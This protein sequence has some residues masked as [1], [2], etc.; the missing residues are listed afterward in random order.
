VTLRDRMALG[1]LREWR[2][3]RD[4]VLAIVSESELDEWIAANPVPADF[5]GDKYDWAWLEMPTQRWLRRVDIW[6]SGW[7]GPSR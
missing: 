4:A 1:E 6:L 5:A 2:R 3:R 7:W